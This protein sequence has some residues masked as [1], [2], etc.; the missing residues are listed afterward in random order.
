MLS[1]AAGAALRRCPVGAAAPGA[2]AVGSRRER[3]GEPGVIDPHEAN[4][5]PAVE[6][7][8]MSAVG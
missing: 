2:A 7:S 1:D 3:S 6:Y 8:R 4:V 5:L